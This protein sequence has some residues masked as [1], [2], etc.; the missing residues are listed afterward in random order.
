H[1]TLL[2]TAGTAVGG[3]HVSLEGELKGHRDVP[4]TFPRAAPA[5][6]ELPG[7]REG[8]ALVEDRRAG[9]VVAETYKARGQAVRIAVAPGDYR[10][11]V[12]HGGVVS[13]CELRAS[14]DGGAAVVDLERCASEPIAIAA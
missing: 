2:A 5:A 14:T 9:A 4:L 11:L 7:A 8:Q 10:V 3:Q 12:R 6:I 1:Q 13:R